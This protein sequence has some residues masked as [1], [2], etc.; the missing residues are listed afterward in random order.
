MLQRVSPPSRLRAG[1]FYPT[2]VS[3]R[4]R[5]D[6]TLRTL[7]VRAWRVRPPRS[8]RARSRVPEELLKIQVDRGRTV[9]DAAPNLG[10]SA[11]VR[12]RADDLHRSILGSSN[13]NNRRSFSRPRRGRQL[14]AILGWS[15]FLWSLF[16]LVL[17]KSC[18]K[19]GL[20]NQLRPAWGPRPLFRGGPQ[21][22]RPRPR[23]AFLE[24]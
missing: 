10:P 15:H 8:Y 3:T 11:V 9:F 13:E 14:V 12:R 17:Y 18:Q 7:R 21:A 16:R 24:P 4:P 1:G 22:P 23:R 19:C 6:L 2:P 20:E 5:I